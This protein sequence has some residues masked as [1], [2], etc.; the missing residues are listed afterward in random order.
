[1]KLILPLIVTIG[2]LT[3]MAP[4]ATAQDYDKGLEAAQRG[5]FQL[6]LQEWLPL[7]EQGNSDAQKDWE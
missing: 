3:N 7:A 5:D 6:A 2:I 4:I 1:M